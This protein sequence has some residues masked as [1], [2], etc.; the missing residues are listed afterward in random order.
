MTDQPLLIKRL[1]QVRVLNKNDREVGE[2]MRGRFYLVFV[3]DVLYQF[4][5]IL[6]HDRYYYHERI[7]VIYDKFKKPSVLGGFSVYQRQYLSK[8]SIAFTFCFC[9]ACM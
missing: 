8:S 7:E 9:I 3:L 1:L 4:I 2:L 5:Y 6:C